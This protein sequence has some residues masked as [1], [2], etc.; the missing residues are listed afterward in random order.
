MED[1]EETQHSKP[2][3]G[4]RPASGEAGVLSDDNS[5]DSSGFIVEDDSQTVTAQL[6]TEFSSRSH[7]D[8]SHHF[9]IIF[10]FF[11]HIAVHP[12]SHRRAFMED[13]M[14]R[15][16]LQYHLLFCHPKTQFSVDQE[17]FSVPLKVSRRKLSGIRDSLVAS[18]VWLPKFKNALGKYPTFELIPLDFAVPSCDAC[19]L[20]GRMSTLL[21]RLGGIPYD[22]LGFKDQVSHLI[23]VLSVSN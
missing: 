4:A 7:D 14:K 17:Y 6:P 19:H 12:A 23:S 22:N 20:G 5:D 1:E 16:T 21:G 2:F 9:K 11:V 15:V 10:Q 8:L 13:Q 3:K 18:S